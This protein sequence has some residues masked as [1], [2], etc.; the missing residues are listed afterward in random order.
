MAIGGAGRLEHADGAEAALR[1]HGEAADRDERD[2]QH[3]EHE[4]RERDGLGVERVRWAT[5]A[6][7][8][9]CRPI[10]LERTPGASNSAT[11]RVG[12]FTLPRRD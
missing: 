4:R 3:P 1:Q 7:V 8:C 11:T 5:E 6:G 2:E 9:T 12:A 10:E